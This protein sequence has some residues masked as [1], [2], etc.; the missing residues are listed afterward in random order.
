MVVPCYLMM[1]VLLAY[2]TY[3]SISVY[4]TPAFNSPDL[5][6]GKILR[7]P[8]AWITVDTSD[9]YCNIPTRQQGEDAYYWKFADPDAIP[10]AVD[11]PIDLVNRVLYP[12]RRRRK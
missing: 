10:E 8:Y 3:A 9:R 12:T 4:L 6:T 2:F 1:V 5:I 7:T 11:L